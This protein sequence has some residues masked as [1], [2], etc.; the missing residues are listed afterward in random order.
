MKSLNDREGKEAIIV[1]IFCQVVSRSARHRER[2]GSSSFR[3][4]DTDNIYICVRFMSPDQISC[5]F[6]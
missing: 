3:P 1:R 4:S 5:M 6:D 2:D